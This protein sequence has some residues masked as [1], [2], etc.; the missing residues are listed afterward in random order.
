MKTFEELHPDLATSPYCGTVNRYTREEFID[1]RS[2]LVESWERNA[3]G[4]MVDVLERDKLAKEL[5]DAKHKYENLL[6]LY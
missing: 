5:E 1:G 3:D 6:Y 2:T 4:V